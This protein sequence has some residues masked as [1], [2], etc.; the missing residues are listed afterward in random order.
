M[1]K[2]VKIN[3]VKYILLEPILVDTSN[4]EMGEKYIEHTQVN[5]DRYTIFKKDYDTQTVENS[6][7]FK[8]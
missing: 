5:P 4:L 6:W 2:I 8:K 3:G 1:D 7:K